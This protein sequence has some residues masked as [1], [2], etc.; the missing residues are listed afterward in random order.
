LSYHFHPL[1]RQKLYFAQQPIEIGFFAQGYSAEE[2]TILNIHV[3]Q[4]GCGDCFSV[5]ISSKGEVYTWGM[6][7]QGQ[8][9]ITLRKGMI[10]NMIDANG[11]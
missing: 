8:L 2:K 10:S 4:V 1:T 3:T 9:G 7:T 6:G 5:A 11:I